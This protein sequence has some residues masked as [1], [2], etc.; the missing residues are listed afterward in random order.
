MQAPS[1]RAFVLYPGRRDCDGER[2]A[3]RD[4]AVREHIPVVQLL[5]CLPTM[6]FVADY[7]R[8]IYPVPE[9]AIRGDCGVERFWI[10]AFDDSMG[11]PEH[12]QFLGQNGR[13]VD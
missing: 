9:V 7:H 12:A 4:A 5:A 11:A 8:R 3:P 2:L 10:G 6:N 13:L 1:Q